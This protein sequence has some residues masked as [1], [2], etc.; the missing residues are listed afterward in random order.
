M[1]REWQKLA[2]PQEVNWPSYYGFTYDP[3]KLRTWALCGCGGRCRGGLALAVG[4]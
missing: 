3:E 4:A 1:S 2:G